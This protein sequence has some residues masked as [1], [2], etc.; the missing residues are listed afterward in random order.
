M[1][2]FI[3]FINRFNFIIII[4][5]QLIIIHLIVFIISIYLILICIHFT[6]KYI[7]L[8]FIS[9]LNLINKFINQYYLN[10]IFTIQ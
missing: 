7:Y 10:F 6:V 1:F 9:A 8:R 5:N 4:F 2:L 3:Y